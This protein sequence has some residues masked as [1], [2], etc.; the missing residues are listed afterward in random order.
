VNW[1]RWWLPWTVEAI[2]RASEVLPVP[3]ASS[4]SRCPRVS[5]DVRASRMT[6]S[7]PSTARATLPTSLSKVSANHADCSGV[8]AIGSA[9][10]SGRCGGG[11][12]ASWPV[13]RLGVLAADLDAHLVVEAVVAV[14]AQQ[15]DLAVRWRRLVVAG[16]E[17][18]PAARGGLGLARDLL[19]PGRAPV[20]EVHDEV[21][22]R[23]AVLARGLRSGRDPHA[24]LGRRWRVVR[25]S[26]GA[27]DGRVVALA[28]AGP[29]LRCHG[30]GGRGGHVAAA[31][32][33]GVAPRPAVDPELGRRGSAVLATGAPR[34]R[35][36]AVAV[37]RARERRLRGRAVRPHGVR[38]G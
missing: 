31:G 16:R 4:R 9:P 8:I 28:V 1:M 25:G 30:R 37:A 5:I 7:L 24:L 32:P 21:V 3:G 26:R 11:R 19:C 13:A 10:G 22:A 20:L 33:G 2:A 38:G 12:G 27:H 23:R 29:G 17:R 34:E 18:A 15:L 14:V 6:S 35:H 36:L